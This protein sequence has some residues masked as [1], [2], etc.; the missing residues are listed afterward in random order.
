MAVDVQP[1]LRCLITNEDVPSEAICTAH[2]LS[3]SEV[4]DPKVRSLQAVRP[5]FAGSHPM[6]SQNE[7]KLCLTELPLFVYRYKSS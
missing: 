7:S 2:V 4:E 5:H 3:E 6:R 1:E